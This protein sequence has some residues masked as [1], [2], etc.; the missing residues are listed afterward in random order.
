MKNDEQ[1]LKELYDAAFSVF[2][3]VIHFPDDGRIS[4][5]KQILNETKNELER[6]DRRQERLSNPPPTKKSKLR[7]K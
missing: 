3:T 6:K 4:R 7:D 5:L 1:L 2:Q